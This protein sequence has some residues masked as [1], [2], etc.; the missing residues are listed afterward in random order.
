M[1]AMG[2]A[3]EERVSCCLM[4]IDFWFCEVKESS[5]NVLYNNVNILKTS[6]LYL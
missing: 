1:V 5:G 2:W 4:G 6:E 3:D